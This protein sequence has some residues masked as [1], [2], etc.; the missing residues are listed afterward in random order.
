MNK[1]LNVLGIT[2]TKCF[3][4]GNEFDKG[5][6]NARLE[7]GKPITKYHCFCDLCYRKWYLDDL[8]RKIA[9]DPQVLRDIANASGYII[10]KVVR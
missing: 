2:T 8:K 1:Q 5:V 3:G 10:K 6:L 7:K 9:N 4:C